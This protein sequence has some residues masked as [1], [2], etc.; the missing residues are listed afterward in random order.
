[1]CKPVISVT[2]QDFFQAQFTEQLLYQALGVGAPVWMGIVVI[3]AW[4][5]E[6]TRSSPQNSALPL[7]HNCP[8]HRTQYKGGFTGTMLGALFFSY[9]KQQIYLACEKWPACSVG[10]T[11]LGKALDVRDGKLK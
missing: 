11:I 5:L 10:A 9:W 3:E 8:T 1:M 7:R 4:R 6:L 2:R